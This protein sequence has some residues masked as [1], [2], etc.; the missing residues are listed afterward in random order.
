MSE[1]QELPAIKSVF[2]SKSDLIGAGASGLCMLHCL[3]TPVIFAVQTTS[4]TCSDISPSW[5][6][7]VD[8]LFLV[9]TLGAIF[10]TSK[11][12]SS[13][14]IPQALFGIWLLLALLI[15]DQSLH[16]IGLPHA[17]MYIPAFGLIGLHI[18]NRQ[19]CQCQ[20]D[21]CCVTP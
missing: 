17:L 12:T 7:G 19:Y 13:N 3:M 16:V 11:T 1:A 21:Q 6:K 10:Y 15:I 18:Y 20:D 8:Y 2:R 9:I 5:W 14:W 4:L